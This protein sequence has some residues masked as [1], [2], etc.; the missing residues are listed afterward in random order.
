MIKKFL[1]LGVIVYVLG[2]NV[3]PVFAGNPNPP[4]LTPTLTKLHQKDPALYPIGSSYDLSDEEYSNF[5]ITKYLIEEVGGEKTITPKELFIQMHTLGNDA[6]TS[7]HYYQ[8]QTTGGNK[9][10]TTH[11]VGNVDLTVKTTLSDKVN[12]P[13]VNNGAMG[14]VTA[15]FVDNVGVSSTG[16]AFMNGAAGT[17]GSITGDFIHNYISMSDGNVKG[18]AIY[19]EGVING[20]ITGNFVGNNSSSNS[21]FM[22]QSYGGAIYNDGSING[23]ITGDFIGNYA[24]SAP[25]FPGFSSIARGGAIWNGDE[26]STISNIYG[27]FI[28]NYV[29]GETSSSG[30]AISNYGSINNITGDFI[31]N[32]ATGYQDSKGGAVHNNGTINNITGDFIGNY[33]GSSSFMGSSGG[34]IYNDGTINNITGDFIGNHVSGTSSSFGGALINYGKITITDSSFISNYASSTNSLGGAIYTQISGAS[35]YINLVAQNKDMYFTGNYTTNDGGVTKTSNAIYIY[36]VSPISLNLNANTD[37]SIVFNDSISSDNGNYN[38]TININ[39]THDLVASVNSG[40]PISGNVVLN[41]D[42]SGYKGDVNLYNGTIKLGSGKYT[43]KDSAGVLHK[44][45][46]T[47]PTLFYNANSF[48]VYGGAIDFSQAPIKEYSLGKLTLHNDLNMSVKADLG[49]ETMTKISASSLTNAGEYNINVNNI[50]LTSSTDKNNV[51]INFADSTLRDAVKY[52]G[53][54][55]IAYSPIYKYDVNYDQVTGNFNFSHGSGG[56]SN[57][58]NIN[59]AVTV[60]PVAAQSGAYVNQLNSY[61]QSFQNMDY[62]MLMPSYQRMAMKYANRYA[63]LEGGADKTKLQ[64]AVYESKNGGI[65][66]QP[67]TSFEKINFNNGPKINNTSYGTFFGGDTKMIEL[68]RGWDAV[69]SGYA[70]YNGSTQAFSGN[71]IYQNGGQLGIGA[72]FY[73]GNLFTGL[74]ANVGASVGEAYTMYGRDD[75]NMLSSGLAAKTG[76]NFE[77]NGGKFILQPSYMLSYSFVNTF[78]YTNAAGVKISSDP[79][80]AIQMVPGVKFILNT[81][82]GWQPYFGTEVL[83]NIMDKAKYYANDASLPELSLKP[84]IQYGVGVQKRIGEKVTGFAQTMIRNG[85]RTGVALS[86]GF[87]IAVGKDTPR[88]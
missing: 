22:N 85:G 66:L 51:S 55:G 14:D 43:Y 47:T 20:N 69:Y 46:S 24:F 54:S 82:S 75:F 36:G 27:D 52:T 62:T 7:T 26:N 61:S 70:S 78:D 4:G 81:E 74:T 35:G 56:S 49:S 3:S 1:S 71:N 32:Y 40:A 23:N 77:F 50:L 88:L 63:L 59:P 34:A 19:N 12:A 2:L 30:G 53:M 84:Y 6:G 67:Y 39:A 15:N 25:P 18:G 80:N 33:A 44:N 13:I 76:Y 17:V 83:W 5:T 9:S 48:N 87:R 8:W 60:A 11:T 38:K 21:P 68:K 73:K 72:T 45:V 58:D 65:W 41:S 16:A 31:G 28:G 42:M 57:P 79:L 29:N 64:G 37:K 86:F 10:L